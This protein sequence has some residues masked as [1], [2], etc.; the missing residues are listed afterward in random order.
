MVMMFVTLSVC[1]MALYFMMTNAGRRQRTLAWRVAVIAALAGLPLLVP[2]VAPPA[3]AA[4][5]QIALENLDG[6]PFNDRLVMNRIQN[7]EPGT[8]KFPPPPVGSGECCVPVNI[9]HD[10]STL[11]IRNTGD[12]TLN[13]T[14]LTITGPFELVSPPAFPKTINAG[15]Y[16]DVPVRFIAQTA[17]TNGGFHAGSLTITSNDPVKPTTPV[18]LIGLWQSESERFKEPTIYQLAKAFGYRLALEYPGNDT[19][20]FTDSDG[21][22]KTTSVPSQKLS[23]GGLVEALGDEVV[24]AYWKRGDTTAPVTVR[25]LAA[26]HGQG[27][28][29]SIYWYGKGSTSANFLFTHDGREG[30]SLFPHIKAPEGQPPTEQAYKT[31]NPTST[32]VFGFRVATNTWS[33][34]TKNRQ[35]SGCPVTGKCGHHMRFFPVRDRQGNVVQDTYFMF[36]DYYSTTPGVTVNYDYQDNIY[37]ITNI[38][39]EN[40]A[41]V[42]DRAQ[43][44]LVR[45]D[46]GADFGTPYTDTNGNTWRSDRSRYIVTKKDGS[47]ASILDGFFSPVNMPNENPSGDIAGTDDDPLY[48]SYR[49][50]TGSAPRVVTYN[51]PMGRSGR[52]VDLRLLFA[53]R[54]WSEPGKRVFDITVEGNTVRNNFD[55]FAV[56]GKNTATEVD[57]PNLTISDDMLTIV[58]TASADYPSIAGIEVLCRPLCT[59]PEDLTPP[60]TPSGLTATPSADNIVLRWTANTDDTRGYN[61]YRATKETGPFT[62]VNTSLLI[63]NSGTPKYT[64]STAP[65]G[66][67]SYYRVEAVDFSNNPSLPAT[68]SAVRPGV[69]DNTPPTAPS[70]LTA[71]G[72]QDGILLKWTASTDNVA[73]DG[74]N[75]YRAQSASGPFTT[76]INEEPVTGLEFLDT[77]VADNQTFYYQVKAVDSSENVSAAS[78]TASGQRLDGTAPGDPASVT[79]GANGGNFILDWADNTEADLQGYNVYRSATADGQFV[80]LNSA[81]LTAST[82]TD[83]SAAKCLP[84]FYKITALDKMGNESGG[85]LF[86]LNRACLPFSTK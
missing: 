51:I 31:F 36:M 2:N 62:K 73:V 14:N 79:M 11:R 17:G 49:G 32:P 15:A 72:N 70:G 19:I 35:E 9:V 86:T 4:G 61:V 20:T 78:N 28:T 50:N 10:V 21:S 53:E 43:Q 38:R 71:T 69:A 64:D 27:N 16:Y 45:L 66:V 18:E 5:P 68:I 48:R 81:V 55:I 47:K 30:Q 26:Y 59:A 83:M 85:V 1:L 41:G 63:F 25:Q 60:A 84:S 52:N 12:L 7:P 24:S 23:N 8:N 39:P 74:Y 34:P 46:T 3:L 42:P 22:S 80:K 54:F 77:G 6:A 75:V 67:T 44:P 40:A 29:E 33:D 76:P 56:A 58:L 65:S 82:Y 13:I 37:L 57:L